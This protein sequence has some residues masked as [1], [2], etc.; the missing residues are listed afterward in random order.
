MLE[1]DKEPARPGEVVLRVEALEVLDERLNVAVDD[2]TFDVR[3]G[4]IL[5]VAGVQ[6]NGQTELVEAVT[7]MRSAIS[8]HI[9]ILGQDITHATPRRIT[10]LG[11]AHVPED[12]QRDGLVLSYPIADNLALQEYYKP[13]YA[14]GVVGA[15]RDGH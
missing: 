1:V 13:P 14:R 11:V 5:G 6:G 15:E 7:G 12:R 10:Q 4:E 8:G 3:A 9:N 2:V